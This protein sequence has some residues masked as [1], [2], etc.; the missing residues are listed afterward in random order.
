MKRVWVVFLIIW[1][2]GLVYAQSAGKSPV[3][4][5]ME[6][7]M[8][9]LK[10]D[11]PGLRLN[12]I[13]QIAQI[14]STQPEVD[15]SACLKNLEKLAKDDKYNLV[16]IH[17]SLTAVYLQDDSLCQKIKTVY[18]EDPAEFFKRVYNE[19]NSVQMVAN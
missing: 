14:K 15:F 1:G 8:L 5:A 17:A 7:Y 10:S 16:K 12:A 4:Q 13:Y 2:S 11:N 6:G 9:A 19:M 18:K 3:C